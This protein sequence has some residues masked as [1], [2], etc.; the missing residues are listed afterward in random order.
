M[1]TSRVESKAKTACD[2]GA[3]ENHLLQKGCDKSA[4]GII[5]SKSLM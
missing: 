4:L 2:A 1:S 5:L 3:G